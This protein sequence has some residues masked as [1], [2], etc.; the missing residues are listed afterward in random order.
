M[1][2]DQ[3]PLQAAVPRRIEQELDPRVVVTER[4]K[5]TV[6]LDALRDTG[7]EVGG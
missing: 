2:I 4:I 1:A 3:I 6:V 5:R 7:F